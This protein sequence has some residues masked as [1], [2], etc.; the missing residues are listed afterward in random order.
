NIYNAFAQYAIT[1][2]LNAQVELRHRES[3]SGD[4][5]FAFDRRPFFPNL[6][7]DLDQ[8]IARAGFRYSLSPNSDFLLSFI[9]SKRQEQ[10][11]DA[12][13]ISFAPDVFASDLKVDDEGFQVEGQ[14]LYRRDWFNLTSGFGFTHVDRTSDTLFAIEGPIAPF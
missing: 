14:Y 7:R 12:D 3:D 2:Q 4:L 8:D 10:V 6:D 13:T 9:Y 11:T 5:E 1:P